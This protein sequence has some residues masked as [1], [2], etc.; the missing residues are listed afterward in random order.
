MG[1]QKSP[2]RRLPTKTQLS[3]T[4]IPH[5]SDINQ[6]GGKKKWE[7][8]DYGGYKKIEKRN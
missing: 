8:W 7:N 4:K 1:N 5:R 3:S 2:K 6:V